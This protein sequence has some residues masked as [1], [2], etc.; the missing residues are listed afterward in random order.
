MQPGM[1]VCFELND[2]SIVKGVRCE[3][4]NSPCSSTLEACLFNPQVNMTDGVCSLHCD[5]D[6]SECPN[7]GA[8]LP[9]FENRADVVHC[10]QR[11]SSM[12][13]CNPPLMCGQFGGQQV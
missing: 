13:D 3:P 12:G 9:I 2:P 10:L 5:K 1:A 4:M 11:C 6:K 8:C 7:D